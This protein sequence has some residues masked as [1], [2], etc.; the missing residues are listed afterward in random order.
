MKISKA[1]FSHFK[2]KPDLKVALFHVIQPHRG[3]ILLPVLSLTCRCSAINIRPR[4]PFL[5]L[6][7]KSQKN[8]VPFFRQLVVLRKTCQDSASYQNGFFFFKLTEKLCL[9]AVCEEIARKM[10]RK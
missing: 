8:Q 10:D 2:I 7:P 3:K 1:Y 5:S 9:K 4:P 6:S